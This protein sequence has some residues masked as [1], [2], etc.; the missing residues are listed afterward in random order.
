MGPDE[1]DLRFEP[2]TAADFGADLE[3]PGPDA[4]LAG[5]R[6]RLEAEDCRSDLADGVIEVGDG[7]LDAPH[8][9]GV[10]DEREARLQR[11][12]GGEQPLDDGVV[13]VPGDPL[14]VGSHGEAADP[15]VQPGVLHCDPGRTGQGPDQLLVGL[16]ELGCSQFLGEV[17]VAEHSV[18]DLDRNPEEGPHGRVAGQEA[19]RV[20]VLGEVGQSDGVGIEDQQAEDART[21]G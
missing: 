20:R 9:L 12:P 1:P 18:S 15:N 16:R 6:R 7:G 8:D 14:A 21:F 5:R 10:L 4:P 17:E 3:H 2:E 19:G 13:K 11:Q